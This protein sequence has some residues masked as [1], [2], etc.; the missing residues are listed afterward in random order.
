MK[1]IELTQGEVALVD[2]EDFEELNQYRW[3]A[4]KNGNV[5]YAERSTRG[6]KPRTWVSM[7]RTLMNAPKGMIVD[8]I[9][10]DGLN[11]RRSNLRV[12][13]QRQNLQNMHTGKSSIY[14]GVSWHK[15]VGKWQSQIRIN[16]DYKYLGLFGIEEEA[17]AVYLKAL[18]DMDEICVNEIIKEGEIDAA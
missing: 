3:R 9:D 1:T 17:Y 4:H 6:V 8:H 2:D 14:P 15:A 18:E 10:G 5:F 16:G 12:V 7:H 11:N 13:T